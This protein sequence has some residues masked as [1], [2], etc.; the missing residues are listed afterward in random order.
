VR[1]IKQAPTGSHITR[2][3]CRTAEQRAQ[4]REEADKYLR[5]QRTLDRPSGP[6]N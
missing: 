3:D 1:C 5:Q 2:N 4:D 6:T